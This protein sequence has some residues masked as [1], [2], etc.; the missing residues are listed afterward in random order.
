MSA[1]VARYQLV[2]CDGPR[3]SARGQVAEH[4]QHIESR[5]A[6]PSLAGRLS[7][8]RYDCLS[9]CPAGPNLVVRELG[10][11][12]APPDARPG[13]LHLDGGCHYYGLTTDLLDR[14]IDEHCQ[15]R[16]IEGRY[17]RY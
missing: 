2:V 6:E 11:S 13:M 15:E 10:A 1:A 3:C 14:I 16:P 7:V 17:R 9:R 4:I 12:D 5:A 8:G